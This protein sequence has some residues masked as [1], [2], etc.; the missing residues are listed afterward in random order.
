MVFQYNQGDTSN[1]EETSYFTAGLAL[2]KMCKY[3]G[4]QIYNK[5]LSQ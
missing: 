1:V 4:A 3:V 5:M 2:H